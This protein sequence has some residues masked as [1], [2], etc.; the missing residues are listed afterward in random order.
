MFDK[1]FHPRILLRNPHL[2]TLAEAIF[3]EKR[4]IE[5]AVQHR[6]SVS[7]GDQ[8]VVHDDC[9]ADWSDGDPLVLLLHG[10]CG[11]HQSGYMR[12]VAGKLT[13][14]GIR[15]FRLDHRGCGSGRGLAAQPYNAARSEDVGSVGNFLHDLYPDSPV[16]IVGFSLSGNILLRYLGREQNSVAPNVVAAAAVNPP[17]DLA[18]CV[19]TVQ[20]SAFG[21]YDR[22][23]TRLLYRR[24]RNTPQWR[25]ELPIARVRRLP[26]RIREFDESFTAPASG[27]TSA[28]E[29]YAVG[30]AAAVVGNILVPVLILASEDDPLVPVDS[31]EHLT[32]AANTTLRIE[33]NGGHLRF[34]SG[35]SGD[36]DR[37][38]M[39]WRVVDWITE[40]IMTRAGGR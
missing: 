39:D 25:D 11:C 19:A 4:S 37:H 10:L 16:G 20:R 26:T 2:Q 24:I 9:P 31:F 30:S 29:Y 1:S 32:L 21:L 7:D 35:L 28:D 23:F 8:V 3:P 15:A 12:R 34:I 27:Y 14:R 40:Q 17:V 5:G 22:Y 13:N 38:W 33:R 36:P 6:V 18:R